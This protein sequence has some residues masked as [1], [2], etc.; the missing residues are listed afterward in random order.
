VDVGSISM[1]G[2]VLRRLALLDSVQ[3]Y[4]LAYMIPQRSRVGEIRI[5]V[6]FKLSRF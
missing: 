5:I 1:S 2:M 3:Q 4:C 6:V